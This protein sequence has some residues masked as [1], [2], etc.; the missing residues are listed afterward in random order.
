VEDPSAAVD[1]GM[2]H[3]REGDIESAL[4]TYEEAAVAGDSYAEFRLGF[5]REVH[6]RDLETALDSYRRADDAGEA[7][8]AGNLGRILKER[9]DL[10][11]AE[12]AFGRCFDRGGVRALS[13]HAGLMSI[14][15]DSS[16]VEISEVVAKLC[17][18]EDIWVEA[19]AQA[20]RG[21]DQ[22]LDA[23]D[24]QVGPPIAVF[25][26]MWDRC[27]VAAIEA[28]VASADRAGSPSGA[29]HLGIVLRGRGDH[30]AAAQASRR[31]GER[32][33]PAGWTDAAVSL[34]QIGDLVAAEEVARKGGAEGEAGSWVILGLILDGKGD[35]RG[36][37]E[38]NRKADALGDKDGAFHLG[39][40]LMKEGELADAEQAFIRAHE[41]G[42]PKAAQALQA[43][44]SMR[45]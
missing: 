44:R 14:R 23:V 11:A 43:I 13:D 22:A 35:R 39:V 33:L 40:D 17:R 8:A 6:H 36:S 38:A 21:H 42:E 16:A 9:G 34:M 24:S 2:R 5:L 31:A 41:R 28:G 12:Q 10:L 19:Q 4:K 1:V 3:E 25:S 15:S 30:R 20:R 7:N 27:D 29:Y 32:G 26:G 37:I 45:P 18:V